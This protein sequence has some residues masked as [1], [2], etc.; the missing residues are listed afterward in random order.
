VGLLLPR[1]SVPLGGL[2]ILAILSV[3]RDSEVFDT[4]LASA[5]D[6]I[7]RAVH[8]WRARGGHD[9]DLALLVDG[10]AGGSPKVTAMSCVELEQTIPAFDPTIP[11]AFSSPP[12]RA[13]SCA[14]PMM[15]GSRRMPRR[16]IKAPI[17]TGP[18]NL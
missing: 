4:I 1:R 10:D 6:D 11:I 9:D 12:R 18:P 5:R 7:A 13:R 3:M 2:T 14:P 15:N 17:P 8:D 16:T